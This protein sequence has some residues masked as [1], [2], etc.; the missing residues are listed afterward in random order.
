MTKQKLKGRSGSNAG[1][2]FRYQDAVA[3]WLA[4]QIWT[5]IGDAGIVI[6]EGGDD[7]ERRQASGVSLIQV[8]SRRDHLGPLP[9]SDAAKFIKELWARHDQ[10][11]PTP[12]GLQLI[13]ER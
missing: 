13:V 7:I 8:K 10:I 3:A 1:R 5:G 2:G 11:S 4:V 9:A 12:I 6:P